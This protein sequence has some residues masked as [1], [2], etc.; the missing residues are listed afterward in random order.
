MISRN[1]LTED[2]SENIDDE[3]VDHVREI[4][5]LGVI[6][7]DGLKFDSHIDDIIKKNKPRC[8]VFSDD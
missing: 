8:I 1:R 6:F 2:G 3:T 7:D 4:K 5:Y